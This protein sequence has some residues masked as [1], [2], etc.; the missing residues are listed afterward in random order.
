MLELPVMVSGLGL[1]DLGWRLVELESKVISSCGCHLCLLVS[2]R[3]IREIMSGTENK[4]TKN[5]F[6]E[7]HLGRDQRRVTSSQRLKWPMN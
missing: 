6:K 1:P 5:G 2:G 7:C 4:Q 3:Q